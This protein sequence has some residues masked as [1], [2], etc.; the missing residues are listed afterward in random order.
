MAH[1]DFHKQSLNI[2]KLYTVPH[3]EDNR[4][5]FQVEGVP[6]S[7]AETVHEGVNNVS[8]GSGMEEG[9]TLICGSYSNKTFTKGTT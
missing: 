9:A 7:Q 5:V 2:L 8:Q 4:A 1:F 6:L 3:I